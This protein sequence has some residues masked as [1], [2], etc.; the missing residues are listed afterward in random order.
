MKLRFTRE[1]LDERTLTCKNEV[2][3]AGEPWR[4]IETYML[5]PSG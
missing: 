4:L 1:V 3:V 5:T 2:S